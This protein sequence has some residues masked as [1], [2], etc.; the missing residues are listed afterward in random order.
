MLEIY[1]LDDDRAPNGY[2]FQTLMKNQP[3]L[4][5]QGEHELGYKMRR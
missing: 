4:H 5:G 2:Q 1:A 3:L